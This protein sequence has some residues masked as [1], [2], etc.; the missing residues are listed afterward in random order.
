MPGMRSSRLAVAA[1]P[2][3]PHTPMSPAPTSTAGGADVPCV[4]PGVADGAEGEDPP[5]RDT[6]SRPAKRATP[7]NG[8]ERL[9]TVRP[10]Q[11]EWRRLYCLTAIYRFCRT[12]AI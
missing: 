7:T 12:L 11:R 5:Q 3:A 10:A 2:G 8:A 9:N 4:G 1:T 6:A